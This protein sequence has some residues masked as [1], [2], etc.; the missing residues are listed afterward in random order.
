MQYNTGVICPHHGCGGEIVAEVS[1]L[2]ITAPE[3]IPFGPGGNRYYQPRVTSFHCGYCQTM[4]HH[5]PGKP[6]MGVEILARYEREHTD[7]EE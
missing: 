2:P 4:F 7:T 1:V 5:P 6:D 3:L